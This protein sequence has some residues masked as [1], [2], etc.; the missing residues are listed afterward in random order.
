MGRYQPCPGCQLTLLTER[1]IARFGQCQS[2]YDKLGTKM[3]KAGL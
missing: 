2:C 1:Y 3:A